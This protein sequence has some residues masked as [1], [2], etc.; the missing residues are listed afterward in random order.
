MCAHI[1]TALLLRITDGKKKESCSWWC[2]VCGGQYECR[3]NRILV[4]QTGA[5]AN[6]VKKN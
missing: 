1:A 4:V 6:Q 3:A 5:D 2:A